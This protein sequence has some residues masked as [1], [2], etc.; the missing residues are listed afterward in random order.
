MVYNRDVINEIKSRIDIIEVIGRYVNLKKSGNSYKGLCPFHNETYP[1]L[2]VNPE[3]QIF[4]CF[5]CNVGGDVFYFLEKIERISFFEALK[6]L[7]RE[8]KVNFKD[9]KKQKNSKNYHSKTVITERDIVLLEAENKRDNLKMILRGLELK[10]KWFE[11]YISYLWERANNPAISLA[12]RYSYEAY[13]NY[14]TDNELSVI[15]SEIALTKS[16]FMEV[17][18]EYKKLIYG[19]NYGN[20]RS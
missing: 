8:S 14:L 4:K 12:D 15:D 9:S 1:S 7:A 3:K 17:E 6:K 11:R 16:N 20:R 2:F 19:R 5:G 18:N 10:R 13:A